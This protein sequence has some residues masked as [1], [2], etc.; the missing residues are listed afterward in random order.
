MPTMDPSGQMQ[1]DEAVKL[2]AQGVPE[3]L[4]RQLIGLGTLDP[5]AL[6]RQYDAAAWLR[7]SATSGDF[8]KTLPGAIAQGMMGGMVGKKDKEYAK[9]LRDY[10]T[11]QV[12]ARKNWL[13]TKYPK[14][15]ETGQ[16]TGLP[17]V[18]GLPPED[19]EY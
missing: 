3:E 13:A 1:D 18:T 16:V 10:Q 2:R 11:E 8:A 12:S 14:P 4:I 7:R 9:A 6:S 5:T 15:A 19:E 17:A